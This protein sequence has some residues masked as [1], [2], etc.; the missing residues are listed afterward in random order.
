MSGVA[1]AVLL[2]AT[3]LAE[4]NPPVQPVAPAAPAGGA[5][6]QPGAPVGG[7]S[8]V[9]GGA[10]LRVGMTKAEVMAQIERTPKAGWFV[11]ELDS[12]P[13]AE[14]YKMD[15]WGLSCKHMDGDTSGGG[16]VALSFENEKLT[17]IG[18]VN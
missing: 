10:T 4:A 7:K 16:S 6:A 12:P 18:A 8:I 17:K 2:P 13:T 14:L 5:T 11:P 1:A 15:Q 3:C 9:V